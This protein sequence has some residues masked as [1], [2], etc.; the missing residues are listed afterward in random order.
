M[1]VQNLGDPARPDGAFVTA[2]R[3]VSALEKAW[4]QAN[5][6]EARRAGGAGRTSSPTV[7]AH[8]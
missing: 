3:L 8:E 5:D 4:N 1:V 7:V 6:E 2:A